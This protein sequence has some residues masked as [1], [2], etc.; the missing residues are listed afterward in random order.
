MPL[1]NMPDFSADILEEFAARQRA[2]MLSG[3]QDD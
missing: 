1:I 3:F 2:A